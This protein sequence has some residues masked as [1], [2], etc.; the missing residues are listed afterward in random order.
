MTKQNGIPARYRTAARQRSVQVRVTDDELALLD[1]I[2]ADVQKR[3]G[4]GTHALAIRIALRE[5]AIAH[6]I[7]I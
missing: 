1:R 7:P 5:Y 6:D 4:M 3:T 2:T